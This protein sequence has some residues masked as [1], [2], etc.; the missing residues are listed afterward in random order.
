MG[1]F[2]IVPFI[3]KDLNLAIIALFIAGKNRSQ[4]AGFKKARPNVDATYFTIYMKALLH[5]LQKFIKKVYKKLK[6]IRKVYYI[7]CADTLMLRN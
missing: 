5:K 7:F 2:M 4:G 3:L 6:F 1:L